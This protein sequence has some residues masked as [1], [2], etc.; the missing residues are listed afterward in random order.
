MRAQSERLLNAGWYVRENTQNTWM[1][2]SVPGT[3]H[4]DLMRAGIIQDP[5][6]AK[7]E[8]HVQWVGERTWIYET[9][10]TLTEQ[11]RLLPHLALLFEGLDT[12]ATIVINGKICLEANNMFRTY[13]LPLKGLAQQ[14]NRLQVIFEPAEKIANR[15]ANEA[16]PLVRPCENNRHYVRKAQYHFG[17][18]W[19]PHLVTC[20]IWR[21]VKLLYE[22]PM[23][24]SQSVLPPVQLHQVPDSIGQSFYFTVNGR[25]T[26]MKGANWI[27]AD[28]FLHRV[29]KAHY[30]RLLVQAKQMGMN[31]LRVWGG[32]VYESD[33]FYTLCDS[34]GIWVWQDFMFAGAMYPF[35]DSVFRANVIAEVRDNVSRLRKH[36]CIV[37]WCGNNEIDEAWH[38]WGW[39]KQNSMSLHNTAF[40]WHEYQALFHE[41]I[42]DLLKELDPGRPYI[43]SSPLHGWGREASMNEGDSH[44][45]GVWWGKMPKQVFREKV[46]RFMSEFGMQAMP[47]KETATQFGLQADFSLQDPGLRQHQKH[48]TGYETIDTYLRQTNW[49]KSNF[50]WDTYI[51]A[52]QRMQ[53]EVILE[54]VR[55][56]TNSKGRC[57]G[58]LIWQLNDCWPVCS[59]SLI[60]YNGHPKRVVSDLKTIWNP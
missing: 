39:Q 57:M 43:P 34:L 16:K 36:R 17:W 2:A 20:G 41:T 24:A 7:H 45:W 10:F 55:A 37:L 51:E 32:G 8:Q 35:S 40:L 19:A 46:P 29:T 3:I 15:L 30:R 56:Q 22:A 59:W 4:T 13:H 33:D 60:D 11:E 49:H 53:S 25:P 48:P 38:N 12:Y 28:V 50:T 14:T 1:N 42:P 9:T 21:P 47:S 31:M 52:T 23:P 26:Y 5:F 44:Y 18:D 58:T 27:P 6:L 54:A